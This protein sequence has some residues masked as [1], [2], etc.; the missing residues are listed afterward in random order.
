MS[1]KLYV[2]G[3][4][5][6]KSLRT[7]C[8][9]GFRQFLEKAG[10]QG[11]M[12]RIVACGG[13]RNAYESFVTALEAGDGPAMLLVDAEGPVNSATPWQHLHERDA[14]DRPAGA[15]DQHCYLMVQVMESWFLADRASLS[16]FY[17][18]H[19]NERALPGN[20]KVEQ[21]SKADVIKKLENATRR[22]QKGAYSKGAHSFEI[23][24][25]LDPRRIEEASPHAE[26][27]LQALRPGAAH[28]GG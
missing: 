27:F 17:G 18:Q 13:R 24:G 5:D 7:A 8:R 21:V 4:G 26:R 10:L 3:G 19:F 28:V 20:P 23:L 11:Q 14:W 22:T 2:E 15:T 12:P 16:A 6:S 25:A 1:A 9:K